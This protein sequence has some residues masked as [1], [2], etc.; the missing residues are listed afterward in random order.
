[1]K[2]FKFY[3]TEESFSLDDLDMEFIR[4][5]EQI[6]TFNLNET[7][8]RTLEYKKEI[9]HLF[10]KHFFPG[11]S[12]SD[13][14]DKVD[15]DA[16][17]KVVRQLKA[18]DKERFKKLH[19]YN[20]D[21]VGPGEATLFFIINNAVLGGGGSAGTDLFVDGK[22]Y[23]I[24]GA[25]YNVDENTVSD[26]KLGGTVE[27]QD[28][29]GRLMDLRDRLGIS[30]S[31]T[32]I[33]KNRMKAMR[34]EAPKEFEEIEQEYVERAFQYLNKNDLIIMNNNDAIKN[35]GEAMIVGKIRKRDVGLERLT[36]NTIKPFIRVR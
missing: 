34:R 19:R 24:K 33:S 11:F 8:F 28:L 2:S 27:L 6:T 26:F 10:V 17:N 9:Q 13:T 15:K 30:G 22:L 3:V 21:R 25:K 7:H 4:Q 36:S 29:M 20:L 31:R 35:Q 14:I 5:A 12:L 18:I 1:M 32:E 16:I 23:E